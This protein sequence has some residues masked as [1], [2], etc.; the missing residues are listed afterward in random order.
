MVFEEWEQN[1]LVKSCTLEPGGLFTTKDFEEGVQTLDTAITDMS[2]C[3]VNYWLSKFVQEVSNSSGERY[4]SRSLYSIICGL[5][6]HLSDINVSAALKPLAGCVLVYRYTK[7]RNVNELR[8]NSMYGYEN[9]RN[10]PVYRY[11]RTAPFWPM[12][13]D[14]K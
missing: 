5:K 12:M 3:S 11:T 8:H 9:D 4:P 14:R 6:R 2:V 13:S 7:E 1:R 10:S